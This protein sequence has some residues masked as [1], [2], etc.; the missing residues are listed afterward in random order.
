MLAAT[1]F[2]AILMFIAGIALLTMILLRR[3]YRQIG[4]HRKRY[5]ARPI[6]SQPR[7]ESEWSDAKSDVPAV[8]ERQKVE[9]ADL[10]REV[11]GQIDSK[12]MVLRELIVQSQH[13]IARME[14]LLEQTDGN[15]PR[16]HTDFRR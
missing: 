12:V 16:M 15:E 10:S 1:Q 6:D 2:Q 3:T 13:Q 8:I 14:E 11:H 5:D 9:L 7:P 4:R